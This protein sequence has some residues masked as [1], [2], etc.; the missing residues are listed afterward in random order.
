[1]SLITFIWETKIT[2]N[3]RGTIVEIAVTRTELLKGQN[4]CTSWK[5]THC[6]WH[7]WRREMLLFVV[8]EFFAVVVECWRRDKD[9]V[10]H[11]WTLRELMLTFDLSIS[12]ASQSPYEAKQSINT[13]LRE[14]N[15][16]CRKEKDTTN[17]FHHYYNFTYISYL[18]SSNININQINQDIHITTETFVRINP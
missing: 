4:E 17:S 7:E 8:T 2:L 10:K 5:C 15:C 11:R 14:N 6:C 1:M 16:F 13:A 18:T 9:N 12:V 3:I